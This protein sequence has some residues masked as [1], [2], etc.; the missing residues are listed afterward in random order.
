MPFHSATDS[1]M[2]PRP[3]GSF[4]RALSR[5]R[6]TLG[7]AA[8]AQALGRSGALVSKWCDPDHDALPTLRQAVQ[9]DVAYVLAGAASRRS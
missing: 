6:D 2:K 5:I 3:H 7:E 9:L 1:G 8:C 4:A